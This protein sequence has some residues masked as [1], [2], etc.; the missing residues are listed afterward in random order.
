MPTPPIEYHETIMT[1]YTRADCQLLLESLAQNNLGGH[2]PFDWV[3]TNGQIGHV[4]IF[5]DTD[6]N[7]YAR[8]GTPDPR[9]LYAKLKRAIRI[10]VFRFAVYPEPATP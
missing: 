6:G 3:D 10:R 4:C 1:R 2:V 9:N 5:I 8:K 7:Y